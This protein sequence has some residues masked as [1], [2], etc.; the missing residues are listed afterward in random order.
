ME[1]SIFYIYVYCNPL[2]PGNYSYL[3][4]GIGIDFEYAP[5][6]IGKGK[7]LRLDFHLK[8]AIKYQEIIEEESIQEEKPKYNKHKINT[9]NKIIREEKE[10]IVYKICEN[11]GEETAY[12]LERFFIKL[13]GRADK[14]LGILTNLTD[15]GEGISNP[16]EETIRIRQNT[17]KITLENDPSIMI[18]SGLK[19]KQIRKENPLITILQ[20]EKEMETKRK[21]PSI[22]KKAGKKQSQTKK[23]NPKI[24]E[25]ARQNLIKFYDD[26]PELL[27]LRGSSIKMAKSIDRITVAIA[28]VKQ[29]K[30][31]RDKKSAV[32]YK[33]SR[34]KKLDINFLLEKYFERNNT[35]IIIKSYNELHKDSIENSAFKRFL[36][37]LSFPTPSLHTRK[38]R[39]VEK[40]LK[41][42]E[43]N[44]N[45]VQG[46]IENYERLEE[47]YF[48]KKHK[49]KY[50]Y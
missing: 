32:G 6:Y 43:E 48:N 11:L 28:G 2:K 46:Y 44:K 34:Y 19:N 24:V 8:E 41:F 14:K 35:K 7:D 39:C 38:P 26:N 50:N 47:E 25:N 27:I 40:Y 1:E 23:E 16:S 20:K 30:T 15:G 22:M 5:F 18:K 36:D 21:D 17:R 9:I 13:I 45:K 10:V 42:V 3:E 31:K 33:N 12:L 37:V 29:S 4:N 49:E